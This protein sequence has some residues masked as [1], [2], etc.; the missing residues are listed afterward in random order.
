MPQFRT[1]I[2]YLYGSH[3]SPAGA[4]CWWSADHDIK[5]FRPALTIRYSGSEGLAMGHRKTRRV[6]DGLL[7]IGLAVI[8]IGLMAIM[9]RLA[10]HSASSPPLGSERIVNPVVAAPSGTSRDR[11]GD[12]GA[13]GTV[14]SGSGDRRDSSRQGDAR[15]DL[16]DAAAMARWYLW[17]RPGGEETRTDLW[18]NAPASIGS[19][20]PPDA[21]PAIR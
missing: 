16:R 18:I 2:P 21:S 6:G 17:T 4:G 20:S 5:N 19:T 9:T 7:L 15:L 14:S 3:R 13:G 11:L 12:Q 1:S 8:V 10:E